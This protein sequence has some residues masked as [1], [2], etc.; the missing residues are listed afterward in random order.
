LNLQ[1]GADFSIR[2]GGTAAGTGYD[3][4]ALTG[5]LTLA[6]TLQL[7]LINGFGSTIQS[8]EDFFLTD[9]AT[10]ASGG[11][12]NVSAATGIALADGANGQ[13]FSGGDEFAVFY[14]ANGAG[15]TLNDGSDVALLVVAVPEPGCWQLCVG[16]IAAILFV[17]RL[18]RRK[19]G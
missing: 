9:G 8:G 15:K 1:T 2:L 10:G 16:G 17:A 13:I 11:F 18:R 6:G 4:L 3:Q 19:V 7:S 14:D 12:S 5:G